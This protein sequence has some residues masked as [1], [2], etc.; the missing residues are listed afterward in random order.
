MNSLP[1]E[2]VLHHGSALKVAGAPGRGAS[3]KRSA[4]AFPERESQWRRHS[5]PVL[6]LVPKRRATAG[7][8]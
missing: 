8:L 7:A 6:Q 4:T 3:C 2:N 5:R 1:C